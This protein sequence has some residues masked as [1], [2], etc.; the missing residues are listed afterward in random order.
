MGTT[1][2]KW[3]P[4]ARALLRRT[5]AQQLMRGYLLYEH[6]PHFALLHSKALIDR[7]LPMMSFD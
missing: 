7:A 6:L 4:M 5:F 2:R 1:R 3:E